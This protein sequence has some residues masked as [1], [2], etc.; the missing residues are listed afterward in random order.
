MNQRVV[1]AFV[2]RE[3]DPA[4]SPLR[5]GVG[6][7]FGGL[8][9]VVILGAVFGIIG[10]LTKVGDNAWKSNGSVVVERESGAA[11]V[12]LDG[13]L[14]PALNIASAKLAAGRPN[15]AVYRIAAKSLTE[16]PRGNTIGIAGAPASLPEAK[17]QARLPWTMCAV[18]DSRSWSV[19]LAGTGGP[20]ANELG[21]R[22]LLVKDA[23]KGMNYLIWHG[24]KYQFHDSRTTVPALFGAVTA[25]PVG[26]AWLDAM[27]SGVDIAAITV[28]DR[29]KASSQVPGRRNG[30]VLAAATSSGDQF[31]LVFDDGLAPITALQRAVLDARFPGN[32]IETSVN[33]VGKI[34][35]S[36][37]LNG[38]DPATQPPAA[39]PEL[40]TVNGGETLCAVTGSAA[41]PPTVSIG[42]SAD[43]LTGAVPTQAATSTGRALADAVLV[44]AGRFQLV[45]VPGSGGY[46]L[47][48]DQGVRHAVP[49]A[50]ALARLGY[51]AASAVEVP[52]ALVN[53]IPA[54]VTLDPAAATVV[55]PPLR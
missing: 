11:F 16:A 17:M 51:A 52:T 27:P 39:S 38:Q 30:D 32:P 49:N 48:T 15:P 19:L 4:Q 9:I 10:L 22:G 41:E 6:A 36:T 14:T 40:A 25:T 37:R 3:T 31:Y 2:M 26:T 53:R 18:A 1:S 13:K 45:R 54:G 8:M 35:V 24:R 28:P 43:A 55:A 5:R 33:A 7:L 44:P 12:Y 21:D 29:G 23:A 50:D 47:I 42:G 46:A 34:P 20:A